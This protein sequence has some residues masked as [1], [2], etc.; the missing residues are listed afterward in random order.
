LFNHGIVV[1]IRK[2]ILKNSLII[3]TEGVINIEV[4]VYF[5]QYDC[6]LIILRPTEGDI[7]YG[8]IKSS[9]ENCIMLDC[10][11]VKVKVPKAKLMLPSAFSQNENIWYWEYEERGQRYYYDLEEEVRVKIVEVHFH[12]PN[13]DSTQPRIMEVVG[14]FNQEGLGPVKWWW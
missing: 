4:I 14:V 2:L 3:E 13:P 7:L 11:L 5:I 1:T 6:D 12:K 9:D 8:K 10:D